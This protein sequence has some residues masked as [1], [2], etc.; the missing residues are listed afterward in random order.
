M[1]VLVLGMHRSGTSALAGALEAMGFDLGPDDDVMPADLGNP[2][3]YFELLSIVRANDDLLAHFGGRWDSPPDFA[4]GWSE[5]DAAN[6]FVDSSRSELSELF[7]GD[8]YLLK[9]P[10]ISI[11]LPLWRRITD[12]KHCAV[13]IVRDPLEVAASLT[14]R[15]GLPT[16]TGLALWAYYNRTMLH[17]LRGARVH[18]CNYAELVE[19]PG[20]VLTDFAAS[21]RAWGELSEDVDITAAITSIHPEL[22][23][24]TSVDPVF[25]SEASPLEINEL[26]KLTLD[27]R[28]RHDAFDMGTELEPGWWESPLL[29][30]RRL[31]LQWAL[32]RIAE[33]E[34]HSANLLVENGI[35]RQQ[36][37]AATLEAD[38]LRDRLD[39]IHRL[40]PGP[41][42]RVVSKIVN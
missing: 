20:A 9:D 41:L 36:R 13:V 17:D 10:R 23:R 4:L 38:Q 16:L 30:E 2:E 14:R 24:N 39:R 33:L 6:E 28:G 19:N 1:G 29:E 26:M 32:T 22:R 15:N 5:S 37:D 3:G 27:Q 42:R 40:V 7:K 18:V 34:T 12:D 35:F 11:L 21:L 31:L 25:A 8:H